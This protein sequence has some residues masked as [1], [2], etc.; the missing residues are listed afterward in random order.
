[1]L[2]F[3]AANADEVDIARIFAVKKAT[4]SAQPGRKR[5]VGDDES[6]DNRPGT[7]CAHSMGIF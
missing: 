7:V 1:M 3:A 5:K 6:A 2:S 4:G